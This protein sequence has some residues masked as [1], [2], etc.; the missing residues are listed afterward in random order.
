MIVFGGYTAPSTYHAQ[1][2]SWNGSSWTEVNDLNTGRRETGAGG[3]YTSALCFGGAEPTTSAKTEDWNGVSWTET[4]DLPTAIYG[5][6][7]CGTNTSG[8]LSACLL[9]TSPSP[10]DGLLSRMPSSA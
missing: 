2:E 7:G 3:T 8:A 5:H 9:Y 1:T 6:V 10:R 4:S